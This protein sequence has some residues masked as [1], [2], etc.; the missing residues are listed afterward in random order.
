[1]LAF[2]MSAGEVLLTGLIL[3]GI[4]MAFERIA[5]IEQYSWRQRVP[6]LLMN[7][8]GTVCGMALIWPLGALWQ[9]LGLAPWIVVPLWSWLEPLGC[10]GYAF[11]FLLLV[12]L[13]DFLAYWRH[14]AEHSKWLWPVHA[15]HH[16]PAEL[17]AANSLGHPFQS[18]FSF[19]F[20][21]IPMS[22]IQIDGPATPLAVGLLVSFLEMYIHSPVKL[23]FGPIRRVVVDN[24]FHRIHHSLEERHFDKNFG[25]CLSAWDY[26]FG[27]AHTPERDEWPAVGLDDV[28]APRTI[29][30]FLSIPLPLYSKLLVKPARSTVSEQA[31]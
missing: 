15:V 11:Q 9:S 17:H 28:K 23:H 6:G 4:A 31:L 12:V 25:I 16:S 19:A 3:L 7:L 13:A 2:L 1:M 26:L 30:D 8:V 21:A 5:P 18:F 24:R 10:L 14:R 20:I 22:L 27:T 29:R